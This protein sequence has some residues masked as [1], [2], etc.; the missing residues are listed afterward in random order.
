MTLQTFIAAHKITHA[1]LATAL[2]IDRSTVSLKVGGQRRW[3]EAELVRLL[4]F[5]RQRTGEDVTFEMLFESELSP[6]VGE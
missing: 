5:L 4:A 2:G 1:E 6:A 3:F